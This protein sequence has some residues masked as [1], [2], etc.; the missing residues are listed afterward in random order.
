MKKLSG[1]KIMYSLLGLSVI[2]LASIGFANWVIINTESKSSTITAE[3]GQIK[4]SNL[5]ATILDTSDFT[6]RFDSAEGNHDG[7]ITSG[8]DGKFEKLSFHVDFTL[9]IGSLSSFAGIQIKLGFKSTD[10]G[11]KNFIEKLGTPGYIDTTLLSK[12]YTFE[13]R[14]TT[15]GDTAKDEYLSYEYQIDMEAKVAT[16]KTT[17]T[18]KWGSLFGNR[19]PVYEEGNNSTETLKNFV[20]AFGDFKKTITDDDANSKVVLTITPEM[21]QA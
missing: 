15:T 19:N 3:I 5:S 11:A 21:V 7:T 1:L 14:D 10:G 13:L 9:N 4:D 20:T 2:S 12:I 18:F 17:Y 6:V 8:T 16:I